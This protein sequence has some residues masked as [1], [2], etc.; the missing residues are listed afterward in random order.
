MPF[1]D[2]ISANRQPVMNMSKLAH[3]FVKETVWKIPNNLN[4]GETDSE[5]GRRLY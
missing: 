3:L 5:K 1:N 2:E 4:I